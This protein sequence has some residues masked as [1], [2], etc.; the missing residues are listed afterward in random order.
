MLISLKKLKK[1]VGGNMELDNE[2]ELE[3][4]KEILEWFFKSGVKKR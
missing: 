2:K 3:L 4:E 1:H